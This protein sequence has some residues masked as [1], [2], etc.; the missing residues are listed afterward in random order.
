MVGPLFCVSFMADQSP[1]PLR[2]PREA[3]AHLRCSPKT[4][5]R[6]VEAGTLR[7]VDIGNGKKRPRYMFTDDDLAAF[8]KART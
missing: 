4:L 6:H 5:R 1:T 3:A 2:T 8:I 7:Y